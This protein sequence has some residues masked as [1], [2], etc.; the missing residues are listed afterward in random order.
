MHTKP[1]KMRVQS[2]SLIK[3]NRTNN[4]VN[5]PNILSELKLSLVLLPGSV[6]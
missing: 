5:W 2:N 3:N 4:V 6:I 1:R